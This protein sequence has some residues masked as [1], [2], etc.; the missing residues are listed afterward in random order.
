MFDSSF[1]AGQDHRTDVF[2]HIPKTGGTTLGFP[3]RHLYGPFASVQVSEPPSAYLTL[4]DSQKQTIRLVKGHHSFGLHQHTPGSCLYVTILREPVRRMASMHRM[5][6]KEWPG[7]DV[8]E[9]TLKEFIRSDHPASR[10]NAQ[11]SMIAGVSP[12]ED[13]PEEVLQHAKNNIHDHFAVAGIT[14]RFDET[15]MLIKRRLGWPRYPYYVTSRVGKSSA[16]AGKSPSQREYLDDETRQ[17]IAQENA[18]DVELYKWVRHRF[19]DEVS[20]LGAEFQ[21]EVRDFQALNRR[22]APYIAP[23]LNLTRTVRHA[24]RK[25]IK[26]TH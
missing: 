11:T 13:A 20:S 21:R 15:I 12:G 2:V 5:M 23:F 22:I 10:P 14:E 9:M 3:L 25:R 16:S 17:L 4:S 24:V 1:F 19:D 26:N 8:A 6:K 7:Y 18:L